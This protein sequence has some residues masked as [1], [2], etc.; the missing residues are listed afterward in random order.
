MGS[1]ETLLITLVEL[2]QMSLDYFSNLKNAQFL[3]LTTFRKSGEGIGAPVWFA[4]D[5]N[6]LFV[7]TAATAWK[8]KRIHKNSRVQVG[9]SDMRGKSLGP[10]MEAHARVLNSEERKV[11]DKLLSAKYGLMYKAMSLRIQVSGHEAAF[12]EITPS[13]ANG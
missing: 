12:L 6:R 4:Q 1:V 8:V 2:R 13:A 11:A 5:G 9:P 10:S 7:R 3:N